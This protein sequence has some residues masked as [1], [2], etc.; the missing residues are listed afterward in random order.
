M[1]HH[2]LFIIC[3]LCLPA[4]N[5]AQPVYSGNN[6]LGIHADPQW[7][8][9]YKSE[10]FFKPS[11]IIA[12]DAGNTYSVGYFNRVLRL[13]DKWEIY[14]PKYQYESYFLI[15]HNAS[16][17]LVW[18][19]TAKK[20]VIPRD[21]CFDK[22]GDL[23]VTGIAYDNS[24][25]YSRDSTTADSLKL[26]NGPGIFICKY[27]TAGTPKMV[28]YVGEGKEENAFSIATD[29][30]NNIYIGG[31][32]V[33]RYAKKRSEVHN[34]YLLLQLNDRGELRWKL[35]GDTTGYAAVNDIV[36]DGNDDLIVTGYFK[37]S[38]PFSG[39]RL[40]SNPDVSDA[41]IAK[42][43]GSGKMKWVINTEG[44]YEFNGGES[45]AVDSRQNIYVFGSYAGTLNFTEQ[46]KELPLIKSNNGRDLFILKTDPKGQIQ[47][48]QTAS[49]PR[50]ETPE[51][52]ITDA[53]D[54]IY[55]CGESDGCV[56]STAANKIITYKSSSSV[57]QFIAK[58]DKT[59]ILQWMK[60][61]S[62]YSV[63]YCNS[64]AYD[65]EGNI[66]TLGNFMSNIQFKDLT[67]DKSGSY[68]MVAR[69]DRSALEKN[70]ERLSE[71]SPKLKPDDPQP[72]NI[73]DCNCSTP[74]NPKI[75][76]VPTLSGFISGNEI[77]EF[78]DFPFT[79]LDTF[80]N[81]LFYRDLVFDVSRD[82]AFYKMIL[83]TYRPVVLQLSDSAFSISLT[84]CQI[85]KHQFADIPFS[86]N[87][88]NAIS[89]YEPSFDYKTFDHMARSYYDLMLS[90]SGVSI[91]DLFD[92]ALFDE[93]SIDIR[94]WINDINARNKVQINIA[95]G[96]SLSD[97]I[98]AGLEGSMITPE[99]L[100]FSEFIKDSS[101]VNAINKMESDNLSRY[102]NEYFGEDA[103]QRLNTAILPSVVANFELTKVGLQIEPE[104]IHGW[105]ELNK[106]AF[107]DNTG[108]PVS[109]NILCFVKNFTFDT[110]NGLNISP[111][112]VC[113]TRSEIGNTRF[114]FDCSNLVVDADK[115]QNSFYINKNEQK[116][117][118]YN[119]TI[120]VSKN[121]LIVNPQIS[122]PDFPALYEKSNI[123]NPEITDQGDTTIIVNASS[124]DAYTGLYIE[125]GNLFIPEENNWAQIQVHN[126]LI[127][128]NYFSGVIYC[129]D[130]NGSGIQCGQ[131]KPQ[132][133][134][135]GFKTEWG[136]A[137]GD[138]QA[139]YF[140]YYNPQKK[141]L[142]GKNN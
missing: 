60:T 25:F 130:L 86:L 2:F 18:V 91:G 10:S 17:Q 70:D 6:S 122:I 35:E 81:H 1:K 124:L 117:F 69:F 77:S 61:A 134:A 120:T 112:S 40:N 102:F 23:L 56:F 113:F 80:Y 106:S 20:K 72:V 13:T 15:K 31:N 48:V 125:K 30:K 53:D 58:Y 51:Q 94:K 136:H 89:M 135:A 49:S 74:E 29:S 110:K 16:G 27:D 118:T 54:N 78:P 105:D 5:F 85:A 132:M 39:L 62:G 95:D 11:K 87:Y 41:F 97:S 22:N 141:I 42:Y 116:F 24:V 99:A 140:I 37:N 90:I 111:T 123:N 59:G 7:T 139:I 45:I 121:S 119:D 9:T 21:I 79:G 44:K 55:I 138:L 142:I 63:D 131:L 98:V 33:F 8:A 127:N 14:D 88:S 26:L 4:F 104:V 101:N 43:S 28:K 68:L 129:R 96:E 66:Y 107:R 12:D 84:P 82:G 76:F 71:Q 133:D 75:G 47:W 92:K 137:L 64:I 108:G 83:M 46:E 3:I 38:M 52:I 32:Y 115:K 103:V 65:K 126:V 114:L 57:D 73:T 50:S 93:K 19:C 128:N 67:I 36:V 34:S 109:S 100:F